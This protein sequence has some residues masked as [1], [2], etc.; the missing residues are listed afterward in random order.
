MQQ[1]RKQTNHDLIEKEIR[2]SDL[3]PRKLINLKFMN[4]IEITLFRL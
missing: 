4:T 3:T 2:F 1:D